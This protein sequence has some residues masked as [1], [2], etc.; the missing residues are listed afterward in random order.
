MRRWLMDGAVVVAAG[1]AAAARVA[2]AP[3]LPGDRV[4]D[5]VAYA[6][7]AGMAA[8]LLARRHAPAAVMAVVGA[9]YLAYH[10]RGFPGGAPAV[11]VWVALYSA[12]VAPRRR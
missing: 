3:V 7:V 5:G 12:A 1:A 2:A 8:A 9:L 4:P 6:M 11:V 10:M